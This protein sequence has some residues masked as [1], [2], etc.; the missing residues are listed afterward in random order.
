MN[1]QTF[2]ALIP[3]SCLIDELQYKI[4]GTYVPEK[5]QAQYTKAEKALLQERIE[6][7]KNREFSNPN[8]VLPINEMVRDR[9]SLDADMKVPAPRRNPF[10]TIDNL[11]EIIAKEQEEQDRREGNY[12]RKDKKKDNQESEEELLTKSQYNEIYSDVFTK[13]NRED[14]DLM[15]LKLK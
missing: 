11:E 14:A 13:A 6:F 3:C 15:L 7:N 1:F 10:E 5:R 2:N 8:E 4:L 9:R 12:A